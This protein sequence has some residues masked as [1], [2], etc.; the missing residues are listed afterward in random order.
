MTWTPTLAILAVIHSDS[1]HTISQLWIPYRLQ[2]EHGFKRQNSSTVQPASN[3]IS[4]GEKNTGRD[5]KKN[6]TSEWHFSSF[7]LLVL[8]ALSAWPGQSPEELHKW[9][10]EWHDWKHFPFFPSAPEDLWSW[11]SPGKKNSFFKFCL[12]IC[13][14]SHFFFQ[15]R[16]GKKR[17]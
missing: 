16:K 8:M 7:L 4:V 11:Q 13:S 9:Y 6:V 15:Y 10:G 5:E 1:Q 14:K 17:N 2:R 3:L 12:Y